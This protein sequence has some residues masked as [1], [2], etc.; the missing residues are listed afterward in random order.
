MTEREEYVYK[1][2]DQMKRGKTLIQVPMDEKRVIKA[3][4]EILEGEVGQ[5]QA[6]VGSINEED[7][8]VVCG[9][10][11]IPSDSCDDGDYGE[12]EGL[13]VKTAKRKLLQMGENK[14]SSYHFITTNVAGVHHL[15]NPGCANSNVAPNKAL[16]MINYN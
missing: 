14:K 11:V 8:V 7:V 13:G 12:N 4:K 2:S 16:K 3:L 6:E 1:S 9:F 5:L 15:S 10:Q